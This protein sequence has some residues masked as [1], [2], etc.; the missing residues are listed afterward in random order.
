M[1]SAIGAFAGHIR[2]SHRLA[3]MLAALALISAAGSQGVSAAPVKAG[4]IITFGLGG[5]APNQ[6]TA[7]PGGALW[8]T[9]Y[10]AATDTSAIGK[11]TT[12]GAVTTYDIPSDPGYG[13]TGITRGPGGDLWF[14]E[15]GPDG[16]IGKI[17]T[18]GTVTDA[19]PAVWPG[20]ITPGR[21]GHLWFTSYSGTLGSIGRVTPPGTVTVFSGKGI[22]LP[23]DITAGQDGNMWFTN[24]RNNTIGRITPRGKITDF[25][26]GDI[27]D[28]QDITRGPGGVL[29]FTNY[30]NSTIGTITTAG[31][32]SNYTRP[33]RL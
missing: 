14:T 9:E 18:S 22:Y 13:P 29:W 5:F 16:Y 32:V 31:A 4:D 33:R 21:C 23:Y 6:I 3:A 8:F 1:S 17:S 12:S 19:A 15:G 10:D 25:G 24:Q 2:K 30:V 27:D 11:I 20:T 26:G 7:G 28:P